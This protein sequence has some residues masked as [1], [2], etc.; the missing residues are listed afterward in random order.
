MD[1]KRNVAEVP[2]EVAS[3]SS[4]LIEGEAEEGYVAGVGE[5]EGERNEGGHAER[6][7]R[8]Y[9][10]SLFGNWTPD[11]V[12]RSRMFEVMGG[13]CVVHGVDMFRGGVLRGG[14][15]EGE[16]NDGRWSESVVEVGDR[17]AQ[18]VFWTRLGAPVS[19]RL[20]PVAWSR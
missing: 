6:M 18:E 15:D 8:R 10:Q 17:R 1:L 12:K 19:E 3:I 20:S 2:S 7:W 9:P 11:Q 14:E 13:G 16:R 4:T 5:G